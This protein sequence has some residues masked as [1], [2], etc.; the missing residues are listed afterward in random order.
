MSK[1]SVVK[2]YIYNLGYQFLLIILPLVTTPYISR[3]LGAEGIGIYSYTIS[4]ITYFVLFGSLGIA[5]YAQREIAYVQDEKVRRGRIFWESFFLRAITLCIA[6]VVFFFFFAREGEYAHYYRILLLYILANVFDISYFFQGMEK[7]K[8]LVGRNLAVK[9]LGIVSVFVFIK[10]PQDV[11]KYLLI[12]A[13]SNLIGNL[14]LWF[15]LPKYIIRPNLKRMHLVKHIKPTLIMFLPQIATQIY[16]VLDKAMLGSLLSDKA[17]VGY[18]EQSQKI[19]VVLL[20]LIT[21]LGTV[22]L[23]HISNMHARGKKDEIKQSLVMSFRLVFMFAA[24]MV[25]GLCAVAK[26]LM[27]MFLGDGYEK[28]VT[29]ICVISPIILMIGLS[30]V[31]GIQYL[32]PTKRQLA[33]TSSVA[34][35]AIMNLVLNFALIP[36]FMSVGSAISTVIAETSVFAVQLWFVR[37]EFDFKKIA[38]SSVKYLFSAAVMFAVIM[39]FNR[40]PFYS[41][42]RSV[43]MISDVLIGVVIYLTMLI[44]SKDKLVFFAIDKFLKRGK[45]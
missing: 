15:Y 27:P 41:I 9:F 22:M 11:G 31:V 35:G 18:Y 32:L 19:T 39:W 10:T 43:R 17:E 25:L 24:P 37:R 3:V 4:I 40:Y 45:E 29:I 42:A 20:T 12:Y 23:P 2:N 8:K 28:T 30:N 6:M 36:K 44:I 38:L 14:S 5:M 7:F 21:S 34:T 16:T 13:L 33:F 1:I 26:D